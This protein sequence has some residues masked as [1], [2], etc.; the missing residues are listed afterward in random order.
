[1]L[2]K[3][4]SKNIDPKDTTKGLCDSKLNWT[5]ISHDEFV[6]ISKVADEYDDMKEVIKKLTT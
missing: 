3:K 5:N 6:L 2:L 1:M 4:Q